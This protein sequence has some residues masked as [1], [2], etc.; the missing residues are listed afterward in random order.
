M[1]MIATLLFFATNS[2]PRSLYTNLLLDQS[3]SHHEQKSDLRNLVATPFGLCRLACCWLLRWDLG[4]LAGASHSK[5][6][7]SVDENRTALFRSVVHSLIS[8]ISTNA[9]SHSCP[10]ITFSL[11]NESSESLLLQPFEAPLNFVKQI[12][13]FLEKL[14]TWPRDCGTA[15]MNCQQS[16]PSPM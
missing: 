14:I 8:F 9:R 2:N 10:F 15:I 13:A 12:T 16:F 3:I 1:P 6:K 11:L 4:L 5:K 7:Q